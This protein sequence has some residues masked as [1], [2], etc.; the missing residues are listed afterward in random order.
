MQV[1]HTPGGSCRWA[2][3]RL[4][5]LAGGSGSGCLTYRNHHSV[6]MFDQDGHVI[7]HERSSGLDLS[8]RWCCSCSARSQSEKSRRMRLHDWVNISSKLVLGCKFEQ[9]NGGNEGYR[10]SNVDRLLGRNGPRYM[11]TCS[12]DLDRSSASRFGRS[13]L[14][15]QN[16]ESVNMNR[17]HTVSL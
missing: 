10:S 5:C 16:P 15:E 9:K 7:A 12:E 4:K 3:Y 1:W 17:L 11:L 6:R 8:P 14:L 2:S 13:K